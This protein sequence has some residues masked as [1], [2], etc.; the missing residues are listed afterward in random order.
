MSELQV[1]VDRL[2]ETARFISHKAQVIKDG[3]GKLDGTVGRELLVDGW[4]GGAASAYDE[5][6][7]EWKQG[8]DEIVAA[9]ESSAASLL[10]AADQY[11]MRD[12]ANRDA[13]NQAGEQ[14]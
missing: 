8:A 13:I 7:V 1:E 12:F 9:L 5:S 3:I 6:W 4:Q 10:V 2:R 14:V 11:M